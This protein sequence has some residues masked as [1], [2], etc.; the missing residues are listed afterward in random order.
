MSLDDDDMPT[1]APIASASAD[2]E[3]AP[4]GDEVMDEEIQDFR[5]FR[6]DKNISAQTIRKGEKDFES[7]GT[8]AQEDAL[9][10]SRQA[11][12]EVLSYT[13][14]HQPHSLV[15][16][17]YF[18]DW[19]AEWP[20]KE[21]ESAAG[22]TTPQGT[23]GKEKRPFAHMRDRVVILEG[24]YVSSA[25][26]GRAVTGQPKET[27]ARGKDWLLPE[28]AL[29]LVERGSL[30]LWW[31]TRG[32]EEI[33]PPSKPDLKDGKARPESEPAATSEA[34]LVGQPFEA[35]ATD[36]ANEY[37]MGIPLS[38]QAAYSLLIGNDGERGKVS[39]QKFQVYSNLK[40]AG[41]N[42]LRAPPLAEQST[43]QTP[44]VTLW[45]WLSSLLPSGSD[46][47]PKPYGPL[48][49]PGL[50]RSYVPIYRQMAIVPRHKPSAAPSSLW[51]PEDPFSIHFHIWKAAPKW[52]KLRHPPPDFY[53]AVVD[54]QETGVPT[55]REITALIDATPPAP[56]KPEWTGPGRMYARLK[57]G[58]RNALVAV[59]DHGIINYMRFAEGAFGEELLFERFDSRNAPR[60]GKG[61]GRGGGKNSR[62]GRGG[63]GGR[64]RGRGRR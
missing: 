62:G 47:Q 64:G 33:F 48:V 11:M 42:V 3:D 7:H 12:K 54:A 21:G 50:Y 58:H 40:R 32:L 26:L 35:N 24:S 60:G 63:R 41:Y 5:L 55:F 56:G 59:V 49:Q 6:K 23:Q 45:Q 57:H 16:G 1:T 20:G 52:S 29:Y 53:L 2:Q 27:P 51:L 37:D 4:T 13:R 31:P 30:D 22:K 9:E 43:P 39:L 25:N 18:P 34:D 14:V 61:G 19:W 44:S 38:V 46:H 17:W 8:R 15:R 10:Q 36:E 28:E